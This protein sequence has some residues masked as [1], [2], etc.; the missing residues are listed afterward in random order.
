[1]L[2]TLPGALGQDGRLSMACDE[3]HPFVYSGI[4]EQS[5]VEALP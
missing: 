3:C 1:M 5:Q 4:V 2:A